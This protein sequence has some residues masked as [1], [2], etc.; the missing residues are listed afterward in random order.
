MIFE[1]DSLA[2]FSHPCL[3]SAWELI[4]SHIL[5]SSWKKNWDLDSCI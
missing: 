3:P 1:V 5:N 4:G 2:D